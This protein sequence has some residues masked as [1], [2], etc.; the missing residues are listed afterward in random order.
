MR[1]CSILGIEGWV[2]TAG[3]KPVAHENDVE[4]SMS[5]IVIDARLFERGAISTQNVF[6][7]SP[8]WPSEDAKD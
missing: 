2:C 1:R 5:A 4:R 6:C 8:N 3:F 7:S